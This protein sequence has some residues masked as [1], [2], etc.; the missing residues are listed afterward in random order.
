MRSL[1]LPS[2]VTII[3]YSWLVV[4]IIQRRQGLVIIF[5]SEMSADVLVAQER[6]LRLH[7]F[8]PPTE[9]SEQ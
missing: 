9:P 1:S 4:D 6:S 8:D 3:D 2:L 7:F 5:P